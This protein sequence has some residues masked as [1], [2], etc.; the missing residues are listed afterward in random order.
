MVAIVDA[1]V[2]GMGRT[3]EGEME[4]FDPKA[5]SRVFD[6]ERGVETG[7]ETD[8]DGGLGKIEE[9]EEDGVEGD[10]RVLKLTRFAWLPFGT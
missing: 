8:F 5:G 10:S 4:P 3:F 1:E 7:R 2:D 6:A 9:W